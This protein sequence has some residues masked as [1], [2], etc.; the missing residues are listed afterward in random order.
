[1]Q[2][3]NPYL[4]SIV[5]KKILML[6]T[7]AFVLTGAL[8]ALDKN[9]LAGSFLQLV[10]G[11]KSA[12]TAQNLKISQK[13]GIVY[14]EKQDE[15]GARTQYIFDKK[16]WFLGYELQSDVSTVKATVGMYFRNNGTAIVGVS[17]VLDHFGGPASQATQIAFLEYPCAVIKGESCSPR[18][19]TAELFPALAPEYFVRGDAVQQSAFAERPGSKLVR[20]IIPRSGTSI[21]AMLWLDG[22]KSDAAVLAQDKKILRSTECSV[23]WI[24]KK[25][26]FEIGKC[27]KKISDNL[28]FG[29]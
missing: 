8:H 2:R 11:N 20:F 4:E 16:N 24:K 19:V 22:A 3:A 27:I 14:L 12:F 7:Y 23:T 9:E 18:D 5:F 21:N 10:H 28:Y 13:K 1:M 29:N 6:L 17:L 25:E 15:L 26:K